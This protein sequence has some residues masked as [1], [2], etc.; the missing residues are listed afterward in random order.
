[1][2]G[3]VFAAQVSLSNDWT[4]VFTVI[5]CSLSVMTFQIVEVVL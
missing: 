5:L 3:L 1:M 4:C 2:S